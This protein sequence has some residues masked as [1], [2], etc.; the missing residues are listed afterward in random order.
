MLGPTLFLLYINDLPNLFL[1]SN[2]TCKLFADDVKPYNQSPTQ[3]QNS[4]D[5][6]SEWSDK[7]QLQLAP[8]KCL[9][10][11]LVDFKRSLNLYK[12]HISGHELTRIDKVRDLGILMDSSLRFDKHMDNIAKK[13]ATVFRM[14]LNCTASFSLLPSTYFRARGHNFKLRTGKIRCE[15]TKNFFCN[16]VVRL[17]NSLPTDIVNS[18]SV[19]RSDSAVRELNLN[20]Y[21]TYKRMYFIFIF[22]LR[23]LNLVYC[24]H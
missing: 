16:Q 19:S 1:N 7:W 14:M 20:Q 4:L 2:T 21:L 12:Y 11:S 5:K 18:S 23:E 10:F 17:W 13:A 8:E 6:I 3:L 15:T 24:Y 22:E 9:V